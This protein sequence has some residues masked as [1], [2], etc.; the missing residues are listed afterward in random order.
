ML[1]HLQD[2]LARPVTWFLH[3]RHQ[4]E[5]LQ[6]MIDRLTPA[7]AALRRR[8][9]PAAAK[10]APATDWVA[11][12]VPADLAAAVA[13]T[14]GLFDA[15]DIAEIAEATKQPIDDVPHLHHEIGSGLGLR[16]LQR[17]VDALP[18]DSYWDTL[19]KVA[20][21]DDLAALQRAITLEVLAGAPGSVVD[22]RQ[23][24]EAANRDE[25][26][27]VRRVLAELAESK[28]A[29]LAMLSVAMR[30]LRNLA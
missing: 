10:S 7:A 11:A 13:A 14:D 15:L 25:L 5:P 22:M 18:A 1:L 20:L 24:W 12:G 26:D 9:E 21:G 2:T 6:A 29:D 8:L 30:K 17:Q 19:A 16:R 23:A 28:S 3:P 27:S 4:A